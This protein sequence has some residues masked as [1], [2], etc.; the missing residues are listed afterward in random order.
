MIKKI[1]IVVVFTFMLITIFS[2]TLV[3]VEAPVT[4]VTEKKIPQQLKTDETLDHTIFAIE[5]SLPLSTKEVRIETFIIKENTKEVEIEQAELEKQEEN[6]LKDYMIGFV[7]D[8]QTNAETATEIVNSILKWSE[9]YSFDPLLILSVAQQESDFDPN[10]V[11]SSYDTGIMQI[12]PGTGKGI[13]KQLGLTWD[14]NNLFNIDTNIMYGTYYLSTC[15]KAWEDCYTYG[16]D[17]DYLGLIGYNR[18]VGRTAKEFVEGYPVTSYADK[19]LSIYENLQN[20][21][22]E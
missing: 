19:I 21:Y 15:A 8:Y 1:L 12:I 14:Y 4:F 7:L 18:G 17:L 6:Q 13:A 2:V 10:E 16:Y 9:E 20:N 3:A 22:K 11:G 5:D